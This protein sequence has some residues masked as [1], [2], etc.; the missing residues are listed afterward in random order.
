M[1]EIMECDI[2]VVIKCC[3]G[4]TV[5]RGDYIY[6]Y[7][8]DEFDKYP[9]HNMYKSSSTIYC[10]LEDGTF[11]NK[12]NNIKEA[13]DKLQISY[14]RLQPAIKFRRLID[15]YYCT[16]DNVFDYSG[17]HRYKVA[18]DIYNFETREFVGSFNSIK[19][20]LIYIGKDP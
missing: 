6:R 14:E 18:V 16:P 10:F 20:A 11:Y 1:A 15:G 7:Y 9:T 17:N 19:D 3:K 12:Y 5:P 2:G 8:G 4:K 13:S